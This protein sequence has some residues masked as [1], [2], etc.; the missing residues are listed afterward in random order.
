MLVIPREHEVVLTYGRSGW[1]ILGFLIGIICLA[2]CMIGYLAT[3]PA[4]I[5]G[6]TRA[7]RTMRSLTGWYVNR[8][9]PPLNQA[10][11]SLEAEIE[12]HRSL[13]GGVLVICCLAVI[14]SGAALRN[15]PVRTLIKGHAWY[16]RGMEA[17]R[18][19]HIP[20]SKAHFKKAV[21]TMMPLIKDRTNHDHLDIINAIL[22]TARCYENLERFT[23]AETWYRT[24]LA[25]YPYSRYVGEAHVKMARNFWRQ[26]HASWRR[27]NA[28]MEDGSALSGTDDLRDALRLWARGIHHFKQALDLDPYSVW[29]ERAARELSEHRFLQATPAW[30]KLFKSHPWVK[31]RLAELRAKA[32]A[33]P[34]PGTPPSIK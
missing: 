11:I 32:R 10:G 28:G 27:A 22:M 12:K 15:R 1:E 9:A 3:R 23:E 29:A 34:I 25:E 31:Q 7:G 30:T 20:L 8:I 33:Y 6:N 24:I 17:A 19:H 4:S 16:A 2:G 5:W 26:G 14:I 21:K 13:I 18:Q